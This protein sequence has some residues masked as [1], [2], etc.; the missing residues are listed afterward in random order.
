MTSYKDW[1]ELFSAHSTK[2]LLKLQKKINKELL[3]RLQ[4]EEDR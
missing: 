3:R 1:E 2:D 4:Q